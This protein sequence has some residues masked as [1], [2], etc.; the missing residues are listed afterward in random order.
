[1]TDVMVY[2][3]DGPSASKAGQSLRRHSNHRVLGDLMPGDLPWVITSGKALG[4]ADLST[5]LRNRR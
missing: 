5:G 1:M 4:R 3:P 2:S